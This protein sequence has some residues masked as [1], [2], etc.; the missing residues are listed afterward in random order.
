MAK[1][2]K[3]CT[4]VAPAKCRSMAEP[5]KN[6]VNAAMVSDIARRVRAAWP[7]FDSEKFEPHACRGLGDL[8]MKA[9]VMRVADALEAWLPADFAQAAAVL[10][11]CMQDGLTGWALWPVGEFVARRGLAAPEI[12]LQVLHGLTQRFT[13]EWAIRPFIVEHPDLAFATLL[14]WTGDPSAHVRRLVSE[15]SRPRLPWG[16]QLK[17]LIADPRPTFP[18]LEALLDDESDYVR[19]S[20]ANHLNDIAR[21]HPHLLAEWLERHLPGA[22]RERRML[23]RHASRSLIKR[24]DARVLE[25]WG[26]GRALRGSAALQVAPPRIRLGESVT[27]DVVLS[28]T[29]RRSQA[30]VIDYAIHH[31]KANGA[32]APKVFKGWTLQLGAGET[33]ALRKTHAI[34]PITTRRYF[35]GAH[36]VELLVNGRVQARASFDLSL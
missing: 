22:S 17:G 5:F 24:G 31:V 9:R 33:R 8:E 34:R 16:L 27:L 25:A 30:L 19:R 36:K 28:T 10:Q 13:A 35:A 6:L 15:G 7:A 20:V 21:D 29:A 3:P 23:L 18:L 26:L 11:A 12:A 32:S 2:G 14:Q 1:S 4:C